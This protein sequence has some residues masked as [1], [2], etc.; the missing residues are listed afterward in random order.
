MLLDK[1]WNHLGKRKIPSPMVLIHFIADIF[2][3]GKIEEILSFVVWE[4]MHRLRLFKKS[5]YLVINEK[6][7]NVTIE[8]LL[9]QDELVFDV[10]QHSK[11]KIETPTVSW[12][13]LCFDPD[14]NIWGS[15]IADKNILFFQAKGKKDSTKVFEFPGTIRAIYISGQG[16]IF[17]CS[18]GKLY[19][20]EA[21]AGSTSFECV[22]SFLADDSIF[23]HNNTFTETPGGILL[24][25]EYV[26]IWKSNRW[27]FGANLY[28]SY[29]SGK[30]WNKSEF[31]RQADVN[32]HIHLLRYSPALKK[33]ILTEGDNHKR[34]WVKKDDQ[35]THESMDNLA[36]WETFTRHHIQMGGYTAMAEV[37]N[38]IV[39]GSDYMGGTNFVV[40][41]EDLKKYKR[42]IIPDPWRRGWITNMIVTRDNK[43]WATSMYMYS[44]KNR[45]I[46]MFSQDEG[47]T[48][49]KV[50]DYDG[51]KY[52][53]DIISSS[54]KNQDT[55][56]IKIREYDKA[57]NQVHITKAI[58]CIG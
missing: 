39:F 45:S 17:V 16:V 20:S 38:K 11:I 40:T 2:R 12:H 26:I 51:T 4:F 33:L 15:T 56:Y 5:S 6:L 27:V 34:I 57:D 44:S 24:I 46:L 36:N 14:G 50:L 41:T 53:V 22:L 10:S 43:I 23:R 31:L 35:F 42:K 28:S 49:N 13:I 18:K 25:G 32:K 1:H 9:K 48:W 29:D 3:T 47:E 8:D 19:R 30:T 52:L 21:K 7:I 37:N 58:S 55:L 54:I